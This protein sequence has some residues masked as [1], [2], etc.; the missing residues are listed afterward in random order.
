MNDKNLRQSSRLLWSSWE[1]GEKISTLPKQCR[2]GSKL[3]AYK[4]QK[5]VTEI[6]GSEKVG[7]K[8]AATSKAGQKHIGVTGPLAGSILKKKIKN[9]GAKISIND[10]VMKVAELEFGFRMAA[11]L[12]KKGV[13]YKKEEVLE[14][15]DYLVPTIEIPD[16]RYKD[17]ITVGEEQ[18]IADNACA[19]WLFI[20]TP[21]QKEIT[22]KTDLVNHRVTGYIDNE[23]IPIEGIGSNVL[24][25]PVVALTWIANELTRYDRF[26]EKGDIVTTGT[27]VNPIAISNAKQIRADFGL[28][29]EITARFSNE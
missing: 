22:T 26:L 28:F 1:S 11:N 4:I 8:I 6:S 29:G 20:G 24:G 27:C 21:Y 23:D 5:H 18:L 19:G 25:D 17:F 3:D 15:V 10:N 2:P 14:A 13:D 9:S 12:P 7:W 16:S